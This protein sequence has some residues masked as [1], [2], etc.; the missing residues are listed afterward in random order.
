MIDCLN[1]QKKII[2]HERPSDAAGRNQNM[3]QEKTEEAEETE[4]KSRELE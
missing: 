2:Y 4:E 1:C 3:E